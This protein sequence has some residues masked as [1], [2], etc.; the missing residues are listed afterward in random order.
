MNVAK[1]KKNI[2]NREYFAL[3]LA[4]VYFVFAALLGGG[5]N[6]AYTENMA[7]QVA[8]PLFLAAF[9]WF[10]GKISFSKAQK[11]CVSLFFVFYLVA[12]LQLIPLPAKIW[13]ELPGREA[14]VHGLELLGGGGEAAALS[15]APYETLAG[16][17]RILP[18]LALFVMIVGALRGSL[19]QVIVPSVIA[20]IGVLSAVLGLIQ[21]LDGPRSAFYFYENTNNGSG[22]GIFANANH[23]ASYLLMCLAF[24]GAAAGKIIRNGAEQEIGILIITFSAAFMLITG[25]LVAGSLAGY[26]MLGP[27]VVLSLAILFYKNGDTFYGAQAMTRFVPAPL[28]VLVVAGALSTGGYFLAQSA[29]LPELGVTVINSDGALGRERI[30]ASSYEAIENY[31][32]VG[33]GFGSFQSVYPLY[34]NMDDVTATYINHAHN[35]YLEIVL[36]LGALGAVLIFFTIIVWGVLTWQ[37]WSA[38]SV[39]NDRLRR[40]ASV[41]LGIVIYHSVVDYPLRT[42][43]TATLAALAAAILASS[44][45]KPAC[46][47]AKNQQTA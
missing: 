5:A 24:L 29:I 30:F 41:A 37:V 36:E 28:I 12:V 14:A 16:S 18:P 9:I 7:L 33:A 45:R 47:P 19:G 15:L 10:S 20:L 25:V 11:I 8:A 26:L 46:K 34:E 39:R 17:F 32:P 27:V 4:L 1:K 44:R 13:T 38:P 42:A 2:V 31:F 3:G 40:A 43:T 23:H 35:D 6:A 22:V 21:V